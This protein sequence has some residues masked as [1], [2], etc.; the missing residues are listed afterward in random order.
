[1]TNKF[2]NLTNDELL[3]NLYENLQDNDLLFQ[4]ILDRQDDG[5][6]K[7]GKPIEG[8]LMEH[9]LKEQNKKAS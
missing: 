6:M 3:K 4:E 2:S 7:K 9:Y 1:M 5:R 8:S